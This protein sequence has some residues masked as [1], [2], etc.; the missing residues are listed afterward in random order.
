MSA[1][2]R[3]F[4]AMG[5]QVLGYDRTESPQTVALVEEGAVVYYE[6]EQLLNEELI[7]HK[8]E[9]MIVRTAAI[10]E[11]NEVLQAFMAEGFDIYKRSEVLGMVTEESI[12]LSVAGT[13]GKTTTSCLLASLLAKSEL[14]FTAFLGGISTDLGSNFYHQEKEGSLYTITEADEYD[15]SFLRLSPSAAIITSMDADHLDIYG[16]ESTAREAFIEFS[17]QLENQD[18]LLCALSCQMEGVRTYSAKDAKADYYATKL[19][20]GQDGTAFSIYHG[21]EP[22]IADLFIPMVGWHNL[23]NAVGACVMAKWQGVEDSQIREALANF[24]GIKRRNEF[25]IKTDDLVYIDDYAH[26]PSELEAVLSSTRALYPHKKLTAIFQP[27]LYSRTRDFADGFASSLQLA[28]QLILLP[29]YPARELPI[30]GVSSA[31]IMEKMPE[32]NSLLMNP[33][34]LLEW[35]NAHRVEV[36]LTLGAGDIDRLVQ[37]IE[38]ILNGN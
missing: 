19:K 9:C 13:H 24:K 29:I 27:H 1:L 6:V 2:A 26:H 36:L 34:E 25:I 31:M 37:P 28:D 15:R 32:G 35:L 16:E 17:E 21:G 8:E 4:L 20:Q 23:E 12:N 11:D 7:S 33:D 5:K 3:F 22:Y 38:S 18:Q 10:R 30:E 14:R